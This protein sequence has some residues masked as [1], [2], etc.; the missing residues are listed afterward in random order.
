MITSTLQKI[1]RLIATDP[2]VLR[3]IANKKNKTAY[4]KQLNLVR[5]QFIMEP[6]KKICKATAQ[7]ARSLM[8][9][10]GTR[11]CKTSSMMQLCGWHATGVYPDGVT[12]CQLNQTPYAY[13]GYKYT[14]PVRILVVALKNIMARD[15]LQEYLLKN[16]GSRSAD[17][18]TINI[19]QPKPGVNGLFEKLTVPHFTNG[20][21][22]G[23]SEI[24]FKSVEEGAKA[25]Q[26][27]NFIDCI[28][29]DEEPKEDVFKECLNRTAAMNER[30]TF[31]F[32]SQWA[33]NGQSNVVNYFYFNKEK[34][35]INNYTFYTQSGWRD[36]PFL[37]EQEIEKMKLDY[38]AWELPA[39]MDGVPT[40]GQGKVFGFMISDAKSVIIDDIEMFRVPKHWKLIGGIDP[41]ATSHGYW[42]ACLCAL[43]PST[44]DQFIPGTFYILKDYLRTNSFMDEHA[45]YLQSFFQYKGLPVVCD[46]AGG[47]E[48]NDGL[49][50]I[51]FLQ[52]KQKFRII[53][54]NK[55][56]GTK[57]MKI[58]TIWMLYNRNQFKICRSC[59]D[60]L[61]EF[62]AYAK[63]ENGNIIKKDDHIIDACFYALDKIQYAQE[64]HTLQSGIASGYSSPND[65]CRNL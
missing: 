11:S 8:W 37:S 12:T 32:L 54:A 33:V 13:D 15:I 51:Q 9:L 44:A 64:L 26:G 42:G 41:S 63:D 40:F 7:G 31:L 29:I 22:D 27:F 65:K 49:S 48:N 39:R 36:N 2:D 55:T 50:A 59:I 24:F 47:G 6:L 43:D 30:K 38:P 25:F 1:K 21:Y 61:K 10:G 58:E 28:F 4:I 20:V 23:D 52:Q 17:L 53:F 45:N 35:V 34:D 62:S 18:L 14:R 57:L 19:K 60:A 56:P 3:V 16:M 46:Y 5:S